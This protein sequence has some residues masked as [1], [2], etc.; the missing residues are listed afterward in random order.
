MKLQT[1]K[2][3]RD[4]GP[5]L[6][7]IREELVTA[8][9]DVFEQY[10]FS[11]IETPILERYDV[12]SSKYAGGAEIL[13]ETFKLK[14]QGK[15]DLALRYDLTVPMCRFVGMNPSIKI[16]FKRY[17]IGRV[18][19][20]GPIKLGRY[21][22]FLQCDV[23]IVGCKDMTAD[24]EIINL[25][26]DVFKRLRLDVEIKINNRKILDSILRC[27][28]VSND[29]LE[30][31]ILTIDKLEKFGKDVVKKEL[32]EKK[33]LDK[34][35]KN[36]FEFI[37]IKGTVSE[38]LERLS[39]LLVDEEGKQGIKEIKELFDLIEDKNIIFDTSLAR[40]LSYYTGTVFEVFL[41]KDEIKSAIAAGGRYDKLI[42]SFLNTKQEYP[43][44][45]ISFGLDVITDTLK[46]KQAKKT[47]TQ[48]YVIPI[49][50]FKESLKIAQCFRDAGIKTE[51]DLMSRGPSKNLQYANSKLIPFVAIIGEEEIK[52]N[53]IKLKDMKSGKEKLTTVDVAIAD[54]KK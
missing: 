49:N 19:R 40:G 13:K 3:V 22:E 43:A 47:V 1:A 42:S 15:R 9:K 20:D 30:T 18:F 50:T 25:T 52:Q 38:K 36:I 17:Q 21:R 33:I 6:K 14:D 24:A 41:K 31:V 32:E 48:L 23:D 53:K 7:I 12:L 28:G 37:L 35:V 26:L 39:E 4:F 29:K 46:E 45:G 2:G 51:I 44:V 8:L 34:I 54:L 11:P 16:P 10:G 5:E 27:A